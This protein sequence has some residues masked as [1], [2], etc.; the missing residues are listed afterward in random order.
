VADAEDTVP[1][2]ETAYAMLYLKRELH[3]V[4]SRQD[5]WISV[6]PCGEC[7]GVPSTSVGQQT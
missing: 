2:L 5:E 7:R 4:D 1:S 3:S 6:L